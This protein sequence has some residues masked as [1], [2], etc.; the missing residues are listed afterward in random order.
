MK[1]KISFWAL[2]VFLILAAG[3]AGYYF[4]IAPQ[5]DTETNAA[6]E[7]YE[8]AVTRIGDLTILASGS[9]QVISATETDLSFDENGVLVELLV[10]LGDEIKAGDVLARLETNKT[11]VQIAVDVAKAELASIKAEQGLSEI[12]SNAEIEAARALQAVADAQQ[13]LDNL[14][15]TAPEYASALQELAKAKQAVEDAE[16]AL[17]ILNSSPSED[18]VE[19]AHASLLFKQEDLSDLQ[20]RVSDLEYQIKTAPNEDIKR[21]LYSQL[22]RLNVQFIQQQIEVEEAQYKYNT[23]NDPA[24]PLNLAVAEAQLETA[25]VQLNNAQQVF[26]KIQ[27]SPDPADVALA[28]FEL[29]EAQT[30]WDRLKDGPDLDEVALAEAEVEKAQLELLVAQQQQTFIELT[31]PLDGIILSIN[32]DVGERI[33]TKTLITITDLGQPCLE[34]F[35]DETDLTMVQAGNPVEVTFEALPDEIFTGTIV[36]LNPGLVEQNR[37]PAVRALVLLDDDSYAKP[38][39]L[40]IFGITVQ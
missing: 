32:A 23:L 30:E 5:A 39:S 9:G 21:R 28:E 12:F 13:A 38:V 25:L 6:S 20:D 4:V 36:K 16:M 40:P 35:I 34:I 27:D 22:L 18:A 15:N 1:Q 2:I 14:L 31:A 29:K 8:T 7:S 19:T 3:F 17:Y 11:P 10:G 26:N 24:D 33:D 37:V